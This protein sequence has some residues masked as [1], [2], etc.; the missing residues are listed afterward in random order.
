MLKLNNLY[1]IKHN[2]LDRYVIY[3]SQNDVLVQYDFDILKVRYNLGVLNEHEKK[4]GREMVYKY[5]K[6][7]NCEIEN[8]IR[9]GY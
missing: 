9:R 8:Y 7:E 3:D 1:K 6:I 2:T 5:C 4:N